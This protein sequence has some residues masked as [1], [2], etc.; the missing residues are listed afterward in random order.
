MK[1]LRILMIENN[2][3]LG[4]V[5]QELIS[6]AVSAEVTPLQSVAAAEKELANSSFD[7]AFLD[8]NVT[9]GQTY[10]IAACLV[11]RHIPFAFTSVGLNRHD[12]IPQ[13]LRHAPILSAPYRPAQ[14]KAIL[15]RLEN[16]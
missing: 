14:V 10:E 11:E 7:F 3:W 15:S 2:P 12:D 13:Q 1:T 6:A 4:V 9:N 8:V 5:L 16:N